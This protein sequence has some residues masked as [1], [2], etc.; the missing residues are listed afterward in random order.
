MTRANNT[1]R[2]TSV[3]CCF[4][5][6]YVEIAIRQRYGIANTRWNSDRMMVRQYRSTD[7]DSLILIIFNGIGSIIIV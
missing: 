4:T 1:L 7:C 6:H 3:L 2:C 5:D